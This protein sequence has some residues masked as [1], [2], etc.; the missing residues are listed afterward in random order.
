MFDFEF[1]VLETHLELLRELAQVV[2]SDGDRTKTHG[3]GTHVVGLGALER[4]PLFF[5][6]EVVW[7]RG[8]HDDHVFLS[9][10]GTV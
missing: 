5:L 6:L 7:R 1:G 9:G 8:G 2:L 4:L 3:R 10:G